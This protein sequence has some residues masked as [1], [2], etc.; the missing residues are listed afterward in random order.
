MRCCF[1]FRASKGTTVTFGLCLNLFFWG[2]SNCS[3]PDPYD[4]VILKLVD[5]NPHQL[6]VKEYSLIAETLIRKQPCNLLIFGVGNDSALWMELNKGGYTLFLEDNMYWLQ[7]IQEKLPSIQVYPVHYSTKRS[8]WKKL[9][10]DSDPNSL[11]MHL[12]QQILDTQWDIIFVDAPEGYNDTKPG[13]MNS[14]YMAALL[15][16]RKDSS[17]DV[18]IHDCDREVEAAYST[19]FLHNENLQTTVDRLRHYV[20]SKP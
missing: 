13:R 5:G 2:I 17:T 12:P 10:K 7:H 8:E 3:L 9:L 19:Y 1:R 11:H 14:I 6:S 20:I 18:F 4:R 16:H 15:A